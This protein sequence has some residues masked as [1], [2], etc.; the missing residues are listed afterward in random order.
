MDDFHAV[1]VEECR[2]EE[3]AKFYIK[4]RSHPEH[5]NEFYVVYYDS[6]N[7]KHGDPFVPHYLQQSVTVFDS[8][9]DQPLTFGHYSQEKDTPLALYKGEP[10]L[11]SSFLSIPRTIRRRNR[12]RDVISVSLSSWISEQEACFIQHAR[13][14]FISQSIVAVVLPSPS[15][16]SVDQV[17]TVQQTQETTEEGEGSPGQQEAQQSGE[18]QQEIRESTELPETGHSLESVTSTHAAG[19]DVEGEMMTSSEAGATDRVTYRVTWMDASDS[20]ASQQRVIKFFEIVPTK[21]N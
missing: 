1:K 18:V 9:T 13:Q 6:E 14:S 19:A 5:L 12:Q 21:N 4:P 2:P 20:R 17:D 7:K 8:G 16:Q 3:A 15:G 11:S 10:S